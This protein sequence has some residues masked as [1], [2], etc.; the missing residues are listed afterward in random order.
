MAEQLAP[1][2]SGRRAPR[3]LHLINWLTTGGIERWILQMI[4]EMDRS[5][6][7]L[8][9]LCKGS[10]TGPLAHIAEENGARVWHVPMDWTHVRFASR[11]RKLIRDEGYDIV[12]NHLT[13]YAGLPT[14]VSKSLGVPPIVSFHN[15]AHKSSVVSNPLLLKAR[16]LYGDVSI[17]LAV[18][19][20]D[21]V[22][23]CSEDVVRFHEE[24]YHIPSEKS[25][26]VY[27]GVDIPPAMSDSERA[28]FRRELGVP[29]DA[30]LLLNVGRLAPQKNHAGLLKMMKQLLTTHPTARL[31]LVG[32]GILKDEIEAQIRELGLEERVHLLG[33]RQ[34]VERIMSVSD[35]FVLPSIWEGFGLVAIEASAAGIPVVGSDVPGLREAVRHGETGFLLP[36]ED[37]TLFVNTLRTL[38]DNDTLRNRLAAT[39]RQHVLTK[40]S[41][42]ASATGL[43]ALYDEC[44][45]AGARVQPV[46]T[47]PTV[48]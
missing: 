8:D 37:H 32:G 14:L 33:V 36:V 24:K 15:M 48:Q 3:V 42:R 23:G 29:A 4:E 19:L 12:H 6:Y 25:R 39:G 28:E 10:S 34:D 35:I 44:I 5:R 40:F 27:Y 18:R 30:P 22:T 20:A 41:R 46:I 38:L 11:L 7:E 1:H 17:P 13:V 21:V 16:S 43:S 2:T 45:H 26:V 47:G 31:L 9:V